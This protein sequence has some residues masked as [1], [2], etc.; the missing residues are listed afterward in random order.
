M[1]VADLA[2]F[3]LAKVTRLGAGLKAGS[4]AHMDALERLGVLVPPLLL[5]LEAWKRAAYLKIRSR[6]AIRERLQAGD[7]V[8]QIAA[9]FDVPCRFVETIGANGYDWGYDA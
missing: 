3:R 1:S 9:D 8:A 2:R 7:P 6:I 5:E 4:G